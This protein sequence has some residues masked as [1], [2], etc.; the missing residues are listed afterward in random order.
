[1][2]VLNG[3]EDEGGEGD[4]ERI[5]VEGKEGEGKRE[6]VELRVQVEVLEEEELRGGFRVC[7]WAARPG[8]ETKSTLP[9]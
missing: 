2:A 7:A 4:E 9:F 5:G 1:M 6:V 8:E 3:A